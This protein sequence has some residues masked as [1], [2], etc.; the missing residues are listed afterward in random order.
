MALRF[1]RIS[2][3]RDDKSPEEADTIERVEEIYAKQVKTHR[4]SGGE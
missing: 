1:A 3:I 4:K 2:K